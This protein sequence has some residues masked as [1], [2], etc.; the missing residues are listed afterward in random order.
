[1]LNK[2]HKSTLLVISFVVLL[3]IIPG[4]VWFFRN[5]DPLRESQPGQAEISTTTVDVPPIT[6]TPIVTGNQD[7][8]FSITSLT[9]SPFVTGDQDG[10]FSATPTRQPSRASTTPSFTVTSIQSRFFIVVSDE[11]INT[12]EPTTPLPQN[13]QHFPASLDEA[14]AL[15]GFKIMEPTFLPDGYVL[16]AIDYSAED[17]HVGLLYNTPSNG[18]SNQIYFLQQR[19][20][21]SE[22]Q[23][24]I[25]VSAL[26][27]KLQVNVVPAEYVQGG[28]DDAGSTSTVDRFRWNPYRDLGRFRWEKD[29]YYFQISSGT[30][31]DSTTLR[32]MAESLKQHIATPNATPLPTL[33]FEET[34]SN[35]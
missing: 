31:I 33:I 3:V 22:H 9:P 16:V 12:F 21:F 13:G 8:S 20:D 10:S 24:V 15:A 5:M 32:L 18:Q 25:G 27:Q 7:S 35:E 4:A 11:Y 34:P 30:E 2:Q 1:M 28:F 26:I 19:K 14:E 6:S 23:S 17:Q 29:N